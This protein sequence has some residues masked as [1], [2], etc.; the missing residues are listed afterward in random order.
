MNVW[1]P[2]NV[3]FENP[4]ELTAHSETRLA[5]FSLSL[6]TNSTES[7]FRRC[8]ISGNK[9]SFNRK[10]RRWGRK[11][12]LNP[13]LAQNAILGCVGTYIHGHRDEHF[14]S[15]TNSNHKEARKRGSRSFLLPSV[16][17]IS[18]VPFSWLKHHSVS[19]VSAPSPESNTRRHLGLGEGPQLSWRDQQGKKHRV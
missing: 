8:L 3:C 17:P 2:W 5:W 13:F 7:F 19:W 11:R 12:W 4:I 9:I 18:T 15:G 10:K 14:R 6:P 1:P 16:A